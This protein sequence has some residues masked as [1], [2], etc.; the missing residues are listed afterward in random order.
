MVM[1]LVL[2][3]K[4][5]GHDPWAHLKNVL[6]QLPT[7]MNSRIAGGHRPDAFQHAA[8]AWRS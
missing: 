6:T 7:H 3:V 5:N 2:S 8:F 1:S 4:V